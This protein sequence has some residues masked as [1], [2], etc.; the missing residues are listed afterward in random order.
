MIKPKGFCGIGLDNPKSILNVGSAM[1]ACQVYGAQFLAISGT[2]Y[3]RAPPTDTMKYFRHFPVFQVP[4]LREMV[5]QGCVPV[6]VDIIDGARPLPGYTHPKRA[7]YI[8]G[9]EDATLDE[10]T[11]EWCKDIVYIPTDRCMN[12]AATVNVVLYDRLSKVC[13]G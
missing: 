3:K 1:R 12:L 10:R 11:L 8:F 13:T 5:P 4:D 2:R 6:A 7:F 9:A